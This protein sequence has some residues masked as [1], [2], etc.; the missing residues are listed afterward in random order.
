MNWVS[1]LLA[2]P[3][4]SLRLLVLR[5]LMDRPDDDQEILELKQLQGQDAWLKRFLDLQNM[6]G[7]FRGGEG[8]GGVLGTIPGAYVVGIFWS[9]T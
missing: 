6:D 9:G 3:S 5:D 7:S 1:L 4:P 8:G 2:D